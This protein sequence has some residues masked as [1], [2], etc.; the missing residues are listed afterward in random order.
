MKKALLLIVLAAVGGVIVPL[1]LAG[2]A[3]GRAL[4]A[5]VLL[6]GAVALVFLIDRLRR[7]L[8]RTQFRRR[9]RASISS[10]RSDTPSSQ[11]PGARR[12][13]SNRCAR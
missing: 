2:T 13:S 7:A 5:Y 11:S 9:S 1:T 10:R 12:T 6:L 8:P 3:H 4:L